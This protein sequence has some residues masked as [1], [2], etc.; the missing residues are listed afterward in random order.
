VELSGEGPSGED[1]RTAARSVPT[2]LTIAGSDSA[3]GAG[4][5]ADLK[6]FHRFGVYGT[7]AV[8]LVTAQN[9][10]GV[11]RVQLLEPDVVAAQIAAVVD[12]IGVDA[13]KTGALG[14]GRLVRVVAG[15]A[16]RGRLP[17]L[18]VD[19][20]LVS[21]HGARLL[22]AEGALALREELLPLATLATPNLHEASVLLGERVE[23]ETDMVEAARAL[24]RL[25]PA[26]VLVT[27]GHLA[28]PHAVDVL[29]DGRELVRLCGP[30]HETPHTHGTGCALSAAITA[31]LALGDDLL[32]AVR[33]AKEFVARAIVR[34]PGL[35][36]GNGPL[37]LWA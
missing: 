33:V 7:C 32:R 28:G 25:G 13:A 20:V 22:D 21:K 10:L 9:T 29:Y 12:D 6:T 3:G 2:A 34:A 4:I 17:R 19:P 23:T 36:G 16:A 37:D 5:Q 18:V 31:R 30:R 14:S 35:G 15:A 8:T 27:G 1:P 26:A 24:H 11:S